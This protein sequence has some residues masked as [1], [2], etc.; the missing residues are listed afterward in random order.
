M[1]FQITTKLDKLVTLDERRYEHILDHAEMKNQIERIKETLKE[2]EEIRESVYDKSVWLFYRFYP[3][4]PVTKKYML[5]VVK[6]L[7]SKGFI[8][9]AFYTDE[10]KKGELIWKS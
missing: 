6:V 7:N 2:P 5:V 10:I 1:I 9:T 8:I 3:K 4:T